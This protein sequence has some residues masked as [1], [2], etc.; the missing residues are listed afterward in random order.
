VSS[1]SNAIKGTSRTIER[2]IK[3]FRVLIIIVASIVVVSAAWSAIGLTLIPLSGLLLLFPTITAYFW[4]D[5]RLL[6]TWRSQLMESWKGKQLDL[7]TFHETMTSIPT[8]PKGTLN[9]MLATLPISSNDER[10]ISASTRGAIAVTVTRLNRYHSDPL[11]LNAGA[12]A[13]AASAV[14]FAAGTRAWQPMLAIAVV[15]TMPLLRRWIRLFHLAKMQG[16]VA[17]AV[18]HPDFHRRVYLDFVE[19]LAP[20]LMPILKMP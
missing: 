9:G 3:Y 13:I 16:I 8:L 17:A 20:E 18:Q 5:S 10:V 1:Y 19:K 11:A 7:R 6:D 2:R 12:C 4:I 14:I 15:T